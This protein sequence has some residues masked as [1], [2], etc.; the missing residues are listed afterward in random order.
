[1]KTLSELRD[2]AANKK[3]EG[4]YP[5]YVLRRISPFFTWVLLRLGVSAN[6]VTFTA[7]LIALTGSMMFASSSIYFW[8]AGY[9]F[10]QL[11]LIL[12]CCDGAIASHTDDKTDFGGFLD[13]ISHPITNSALVFFTSFGAYMIT[14]NIYLLVFSASGAIMFTLTSLLEWYRSD[15]EGGLNR[16]TRPDSESSIFGKVIGYGKSLAFA[17]GGLTHPLLAFILIDLLI[18]QG[19]RAYY[20]A[21]MA[22]GGY[23]IV[24][25]RFISLKNT[26]D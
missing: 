9:I 5:K 15:T 19:F 11:Y 6:F 24:V 12:D 13:N 16:G 14:E 8:I 3:S 1:M 25:K 2:F 18:Y 22:V 7:L 26:M 17:K 4:I 21:L 20:P 23:I 10:Y